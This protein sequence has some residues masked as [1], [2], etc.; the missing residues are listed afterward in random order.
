MVARSPEL[1]SGD[2]AETPD[3]IDNKDYRI[4]Q[5]TV[6]GRPM[7]IPDQLKDQRSVGEIQA[8]II[9][10]V[11]EVTPEGVIFADDK[12]RKIL[13]ERFADPV[14]NFPPDPKF[15]TGSK[16]VLTAH[17][18]DKDIHGRFPHDAQQIE[19][20]P[21]SYLRASLAPRVVVPKKPNLAILKDLNTEKI[22]FVSTPT[23]AQ[24]LAMFNPKTKKWEAQVLPAGE[25]GSDHW[26]RM[27]HYPDGFITGMVYYQDQDGIYGFR[28]DQHINRACRDA[29]RR[30]FENVSPEFLEKLFAAQ[31]LADKRWIPK[32]S[33]EPG[34]RYYG[35]FIGYT[36]NMAP[37]LRGQEKEML[38]L[39]TPVGPYRNV[40]VLKIRQMGPR[41]VTKGFGDIK[42]PTNYAGPVEQFAPF[43]DA[44][45]HE[46]VFM[47]DLGNGEK[48]VQEGTSVNYAAVYYRDGKP[49]VR[50]PSLKHGDILPGITMQSVGELVTSYGF[51]IDADHNL[52]QEDLQR[53]DEILVT[54]TAMTVRGV[55]SLDDVDG[56]RLFENKNGD[57]MGEVGQRLAADFKAILD[58]KHPD[59][60]FNDWMQKI[61]SF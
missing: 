6:P 19:Q 10:R 25:L 45:Y 39:G 46:A 20:N 26:E 28:V 47:E 3:D 33:N 53:A 8:G 43:Q 12:E 24:T 29:K 21:P 35:R 34:N 14:G 15:A 17:Y 60:K 57:K 55:G 1:A 48:R 52:T 51:E 49:L 32:L 36:T 9:D 16:I 44:G 31:L 18:N 59:P 13:F 40:D 50:M 56:N 58:R 7:S 41:P 23:D 54:G 30:K 2:A 4:I 11:R 22:P 27:Y 37:P 38:F 42:H 61:V 5:P